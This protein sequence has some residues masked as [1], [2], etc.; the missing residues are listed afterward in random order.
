MYKNKVSKNQ[1]I[2]LSGNKRN[3]IIKGK[4]LK[5]S[6][7]L[8]F[9]G[10][11][12]GINVQNSS[13]LNVNNG[14]TYVA[15]VK[16]NNISNDPKDKKAHYAAVMYKHHQF[17]LAL[18]GDKLYCNFHN[19][20][21]W[22]AYL[23]SPSSLRIKPDKWYHLALVFDISQCIKSW[24]SLD[25]NEA[26]CRRCSRIWNSTRLYTPAKSRCSDSNRAKPMA[27]GMSG[28]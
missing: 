25:N 20:K 6:N 3:G 26:F 10:K 28:I 9:N 17:V 19:G 18:R 4:L 24:G 12:S 14:A 21:K 23:F 15:V 16:F 1:L 5:G 8:I 7:S 13:E 11:D 2:D 22:G 27:S